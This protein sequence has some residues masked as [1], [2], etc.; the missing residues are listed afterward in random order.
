MDMKNDSTKRITEALNLAE[1]SSAAAQKA[2]DARDINHAPPLIYETLAHTLEA[3]A[4]AARHG[5]LG[6]LQNLMPSATFY[7]KVLTK[8]A[9]DP[10]DGVNAIDIGS[11]IG[12]VPE[13]SD[14]ERVGDLFAKLAQG[15]DVLSTMA[16]MLKDGPL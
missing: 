6:V 3:M 5:E 1:V 10:F 11:S 9:A 12:A 15:A 4:L 7:V 13:R 16:S 14:S 8:L 2:I